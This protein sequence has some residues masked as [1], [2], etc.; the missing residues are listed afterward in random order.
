VSTEG[1]AGNSF[2]ALADVRVEDCVNRFGGYV[3]EL[4]ALAV[5][6]GWMKHE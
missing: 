5:A 1:A 6:K 4:T 3:E 2:V